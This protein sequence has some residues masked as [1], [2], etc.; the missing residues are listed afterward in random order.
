[1]RAGAPSTASEVHEAG[2]KHHEQGRPPLRSHHRSSGLP[3]PHP[4]RPPG[5][6][7]VRARLLQRSR[8]REFATAGA[9]PARRLVRHQKR[10]RYLR[11]L[12]RDTTREKFGTVGCVALD[13]EGY[14]AAGTSTGGATCSAMAA[15]ATVDHWCGDLGGQPDVCHLGHRVGEYFIRTAVARDIH[16]RML[17]GGETW[18]AAAERTIQDEMGAWWG[19]RHCRRTARTLPS[20]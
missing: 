19:W 14:L 18:Q 16:A 10:D 6:G 12:E 7:G 20:A 8:S 17:H 2:R 4:S 9:E 3:T 5:H 15:S 11:A 13:R 1:M